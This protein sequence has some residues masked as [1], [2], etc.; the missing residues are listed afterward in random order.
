MANDAQSLAA[1]TRE[2][3]DGAEAPPSDAGEQ[4]RTAPIDDAEMQLRRAL[5]DLDN[6]R[7]RFE[8]EVTRE[9]SD[10]R[11]RV[12]REWL[13]VVDNIERA[14]EHGGDR[15]DGLAAGFRAVYEHALSLLDRLGFPRFDDIGLPFDPRRHEAVGTIESDAPSG[16]IVAAMRPGYGS[17]EPVLRPAAVIVAK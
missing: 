7:K 1:P 16:T 6:L 14:L 11:A 15:D 2:D 8:R 10:E 17:E 5:A 12:A 9:R 13:A 4:E 3:S